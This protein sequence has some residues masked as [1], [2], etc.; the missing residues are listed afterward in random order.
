ME[1]IDLHMHSSFSDGTD[2]PEQLVQSAKASGI[3]LIALTDHN[4]IAGIDAFRKACHKYGQAGIDGIELSTGWPEPGTAPDE[5][6]PEIHV[7]GYF[8][9]FSDFSSSSFE[10]LQKVIREYRVTKIRH[11]E[12]IVKKM[13]DAGIGQGRVTVDGFNAYVRKVSG[14]GN[15]NRVHIARYLMYLN[16]VSSI[17]EAMAVYI[18]KKCPYYVPRRTVTVAEAVDAIHAGSGAAVI[19]HMGEYH[20]TGTRLQAFFDYCLQKGVDG[21]ELLHP[22]NTPED[23]AQ[24]LA[25]ADRVRSESGRTLLLTAGSDFHGTHKLN[26]QAYPWGTPYSWDE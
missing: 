6:P 9:P 3:G 10:P 1:K 7:L 20:F 17:D 26:R 8:P 12:S 2:T 14:S 19:A 16:V 21:F 25:L 22:H 15:Y 24:I 4:T 11:N 23:A 13:E 5:E 18:G